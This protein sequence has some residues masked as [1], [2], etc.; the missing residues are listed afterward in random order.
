MILSICKYISAALWATGEACS[1]A[2]FRSNGFC[3]P[4]LN[5]QR[6]DPGRFCAGLHIS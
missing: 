6:E 3:A 1:L 2:L 5:V 4:R